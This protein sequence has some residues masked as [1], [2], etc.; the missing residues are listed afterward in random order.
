MFLVR[1]WLHAFF[2]SLY[3]R[4]KHSTC[5]PELKWQS[6]WQSEA[7]WKIACKPLLSVYTLFPLTHSVFT[8]YSCLPVPVDIQSFLPIYPLHCVPSS[9]SLP[10]TLLS[11]CLTAVGLLWEVIRKNSTETYT[12]AVENKAFNTFYSSSLRYN[13]KRLGVRRWGGWGKVCRNYQD[14]FREWCRGGNAALVS[15]NFNVPWY[16]MEVSNY[17]YLCLCHTEAKGL[18]WSCLANWQLWLQK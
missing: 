5:F 8:V 15:P 10:L 14:I 6:T 4:W 13:S 1:Q 2:K 3:W 17:L 18:V 7:K 12:A 9:I 11:F 16:L